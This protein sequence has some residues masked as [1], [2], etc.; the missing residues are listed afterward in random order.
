MKDKTLIAVVLDRSGS[1]GTVGVETVGMFNNFLKEQREQPGEASLTL[2]QFDNLYQ[3]DYSDKPI[4]DCPN[5]ILGTTYSPRGMTALYDAIGKTITEVGVKLEKTPEEDRPSKV[6]LVV[7]TDGEENNSKEYTANRVKE[8]IKHQQ[9][10]Y[11]WDII[12]LAAGIDFSKTAATLNVAQS[13]YMNFAGGAVGINS[14]GAT[15]S[16]YASAHRSCTGDAYKS[17]SVSDFVA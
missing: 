9:E 6:L 15:L 14:V 7:I 12:F 2:A 4:K 8:M 5:L 3:V 16:G 17:F 13:K 1:M 10:K 11:S